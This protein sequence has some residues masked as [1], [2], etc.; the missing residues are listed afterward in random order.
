MSDEKKLIVRAT[1]LWIVALIGFDIGFC[2]LWIMSNI[3]PIRILI[4]FVVVVSNFSA[5]IYLIWWTRKSLKQ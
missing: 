2:V 1:V 3:F 5:I 4:C